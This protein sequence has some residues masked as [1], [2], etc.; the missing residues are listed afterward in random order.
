MDFFAHQ[1]AARRRSRRLVVLFALAVAAIV[2]AVYLAATVLLFGAYGE[3]AGDLPLWDRGRLL[4]VAAAVLLVVA[5]GSLYKLAQLREGG[6]AIA[7]LLGGRRVDPATTNLDERRLLNV[8]EEMALAAGVPV[9]TV[10][11]LERELG[12]NAFA[13]GFS[14][15]DAVVAVTRG[16]LVR[17][18]RDELQGVIAHEFSH[19][20]NGDMRL[21]LRLV[22]LLHGI[23]VI[24]LLGEILL[25]SSRFSDGGS[26]RSRK[27]GAPIVLFG[28]AL[29][30]IGWIGIFFGRW[31]KAGVSRQREFLADASAVQ[32][33][34]DPAGIGGALKKIGGLSQS[35]RLL[36]ARAEEASHFY[37]ADGLAPRW[38]ETFS[39]H[40]PLAERIR[41]I[42]P[43]FDGSY[44]KLPPLEEELRRAPAEAG[45]AARPALERALRLAVGAIASGELAASAGAVRREHLARVR[46]LLE[47]IP[48]GIRET[49]REPL[50]A[51]AVVYAL[52]LDSA[53]AV[54][55]AQLERLERHPDAELA[56]WV[57]RL[58]ETLPSD[59]AALR[60]PLVDLA[61]PALRTLSPEQYREFRALVRELAAADRQLS[62]FELALEKA[63]LRHLAPHFGEAKAARADTYSLNGRV[64]ECSRLLSALARA[65]HAE[66]PQVV[67]AFAAG[68][69]RLAA[70]G[71][72]LRLCAPEELTAGNLEAAFDALDRVALPW[73]RALLEAAEL[74]A[75]HD[76]RLDPAEAELLRAIADALG[77]P[78]PPVAAAPAAA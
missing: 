5:L 9:P 58:D 35:S 62:L 27:G 13:A 32:F 65:A 24:A 68:A 41:R 51:Q 15:S 19:L 38:L 31:I 54:R 57:R 20:L 28:L 72:E 26:R 75:A 48:V 18:R 3:D 34:R 25:R 66:E 8:V 30:L 21:N 60:L 7:E 46:A 76:A 73:K 1:D 49:T 6:A 59:R 71:V 42:D 77:I 11:L 78:V 64:A 16:A 67:A 22:G 74:V 47:S 39:T 53:P 63:L 10:Y 44:P 12:I 52:L 45:T 2:V 55:A 23:L 29:Y 43:A 17:L 33:T 56:K 69:A 50:G 70:R 14:P 40:P 4:G 61:L 37:F 36:A